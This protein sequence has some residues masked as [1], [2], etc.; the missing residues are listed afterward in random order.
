MAPIVYVAV[1]DRGAFS[2]VQGMLEPQ[3]L[4]WLQTDPYWINI[5][6]AIDAL[7]HQPASK[8]SRGSVGSTERPHTIFE[9]GGYTGYE[10]PSQSKLGIVDY[11]K[12]LGAKRVLAFVRAFRRVN[13]EW[14]DDLGHKLRRALKDTPDHPYTDC[15][16]E[17]TTPTQTIF[18][19]GLIQVYRASD[20][21]SRAHID[22]DAS[23]L[24]GGLTVLGQRSVQHR[25]EI[26]YTDRGVDTAAS[27]GG[28]DHD[29]ESTSKPPAWQSIHQEPG[30]IYIGN[31]SAAK[32]FVAHAVATETPLDGTDVHITVTLRTDIFGTT[33][34]HAGL[35]PTTDD[36]YAPELRS[37][38]NMVVAR[39]VSERPPHMPSLTD[40]IIESYLDRLI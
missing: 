14:L 26:P 22:G 30:S 17:Q 36:V 11:S 27:S 20:Y 24:L 8:R 33:R 28:S 34:K 13:T 12:R 23:I 19:Y 18:S 10:A 3:L 29:G 38:I 35:E 31:F 2:V 6:A 5:V 37:L 1:A 21:D 32:H 15:F 9:E 16:F 40:A 7:R 39:F 25:S 4:Q